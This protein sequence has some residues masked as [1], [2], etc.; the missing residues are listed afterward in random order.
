MNGLLTPLRFIVVVQ[1]TATTTIRGREGQILATE[2]RLAN[3]YCI[4]VGEGGGGGGE[5]QG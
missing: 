3:G 5:G 4:T 1:F 2:A